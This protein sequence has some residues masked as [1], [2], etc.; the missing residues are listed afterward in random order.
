MEFEETNMEFKETKVETKNNKSN[1]NL[2]QEG[3]FQSQRRNLLTTK[4]IPMLRSLLEN[5]R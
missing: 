3:L 4:S 1:K 2:R 5:S